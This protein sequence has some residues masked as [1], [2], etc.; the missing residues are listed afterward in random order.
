MARLE[1][2]MNQ[3]EERSVDVDGRYALLCVTLKMSSAS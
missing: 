3:D 2:P 1:L